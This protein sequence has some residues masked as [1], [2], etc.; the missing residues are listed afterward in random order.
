MRWQEIQERIWQCQVCRG[1]ARVETNVRQQTAQPAG[2][3]KLLVIS[4]APP[5]VEG[6]KEKTKAA[7]ATT[8]EDDKLRLFLESALQADWQTLTTSGVTLL[9]T[10]KCAIVPVGGG[11]QNP[12]AKVVDRC[13]PIHLAAELRETKPKVV[14]TL[15]RMAYRAFCLAAEQLGTGAPPAKLKLSIPPKRAQPGEE[16]HPIDLLGRTTLLL[17]SAFPRG[18][19]RKEAIE[20]V[21]RAMTTAGVDHP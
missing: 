5:F 18:P 9:H 7:S 3:T 1:D 20:V 21:R 19:G 6:V 14:V 17:T 2:E 13:A 11:F 8:S 4:L 16:G 10:V 12:P 15:G